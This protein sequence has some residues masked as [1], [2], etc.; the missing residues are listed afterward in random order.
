MFEP[1]LIE[2]WPWCYRGTLAR[3][4]IELQPQDNEQDMVRLLQLLRD[5]ACGLTLLHS[6]NIV[7]A[8]LVSHVGP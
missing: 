4:A 2:N 6:Y 5:V 3:Q 1:W 7:H 8:D